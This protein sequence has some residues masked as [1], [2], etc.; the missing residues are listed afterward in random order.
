MNTMNLIGRGGVAILGLIAA[1]GFAGV[2]SA[3]EVTFS[4]TVVALETAEYAQPNGTTREVQELEVAY[5]DEKTKRPAQKVF[6]IDSETRVLRGD[7]SLSLAEA[8][9]QK[10]ETVEVVVNHDTP[11]DL[12]LEVRLQAP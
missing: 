3:H 11:G 5:V 9:L 10:G 4:G 8:A 7:K 1:S 6:T 12:A 2:L